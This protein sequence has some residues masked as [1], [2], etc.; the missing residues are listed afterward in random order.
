[1]T[2]IYPALVTP[3]KDD[4]GYHV[5]FLDLEGCYA[6]GPDLDDA[7]QN[8]REAANDWI[9]LELDEEYPVMPEVTHHEDVDIPE[10]SFIRDIMI[11]V[12]LLPDYD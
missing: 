8:A 5:E 2:F 1:M 9:M 4:K 10:G 7:L 6:D 11:I 12:R 3:H